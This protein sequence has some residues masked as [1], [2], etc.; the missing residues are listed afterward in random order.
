LGGVFFQ[1][2]I[3]RIQQ[4][5]HQD[6]KYLVFDD[7]RQAEEGDYVLHPFFGGF[8]KIMKVYYGY[9]MSDYD[10]V[11]IQGVTSLITRKQRHV[12]AAKWEALMDEDKARIDENTVCF[13]TEE[14]DQLLRSDEGKVVLTFTDA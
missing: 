12:V 4:L 6:T 8:S 13:V 2:Q 14:N 10:F 3:G 7:G 1:R 9:D 11:A 5:K